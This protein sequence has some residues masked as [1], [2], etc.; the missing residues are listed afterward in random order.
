MG[1]KRVAETA[2]NVDRKKQRHTLN[3]TKERNVPCE[4]VTCKVKYLLPSLEYKYMGEEMCMER[5]ENVTR[6]F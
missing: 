2:N 4:N 1:K 5:T 3:M 6:M